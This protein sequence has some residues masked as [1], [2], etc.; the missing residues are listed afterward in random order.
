MSFPFP[1]SDTFP[2]SIPSLPLFCLPLSIQ[3]ISNRLYW[4]DRGILIVPK[5]CEKR[6]EKNHAALYLPLHV[7]LAFQ[8]SR[9]LTL[10]LP[11]CKHFRQQK[12]LT[13]SFL[14]VHLPQPLL[15]L[16][17][18]RLCP[19]VPW[20]KDTLFVFPIRDEKTPIWMDWRLCCLQLC[21]FLLCTLFPLV[22]P[23]WTLF[24]LFVQLGGWVIH[25]L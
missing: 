25:H 20:N 24:S 19:S 6:R 15:C 5:L 16:G 4:H 21:L 9:I 12:A 18:L 10:S 3:L 11:A 22:S 2:P 23:P 1:C 13:I 7:S 17:I 14:V 8:P